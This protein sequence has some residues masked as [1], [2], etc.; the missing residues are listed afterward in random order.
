MLQLTSAAALSTAESISDPACNLSI[1][2]ACVCVCVGREELT[3][4]MLILE[5]RTSDDDTPE[6]EASFGTADSSENITLQ[7][8]TS[9]LPGVCFCC[10]LCLCVCLCV[11]MP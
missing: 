3:Y 2:C 11:R 7:G 5:P 8:A 10:D 9:D 6:S 1:A 4:E